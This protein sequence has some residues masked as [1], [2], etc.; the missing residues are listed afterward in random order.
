MKKILVLCQ[1]F[2]NYPFPRINI[3][4]NNYLVSG[5]LAHQLKIEE[6]VQGFKHLVDS[7]APCS[8]RLFYVS[9]Y[10]IFLALSGNIKEALLQILQEERIQ[11]I[12]E[13]EEKIY[14]Y[15]IAYN[16][17]VYQFLLGNNKESLDILKKL[18]KQ[19]IS[20]ELRDDSIYT[21]KRVSQV[22]KYISNK[23]CLVTP[24]Q[25]EDILLQNSSEFQATPWNYYGKGYAFTIVFNWDL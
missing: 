16:S 24:K 12:K 13:D 23:G 3:F 21:E 11:N 20:S 19:M 25:W 6:C 8:E 14:N 2:S 5:Y 4:I 15:R 18:H 7:I 22:I 9:N 17:G 1:Q 10:S